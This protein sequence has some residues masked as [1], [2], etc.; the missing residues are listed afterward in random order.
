MRARATA[1]IALLL[2]L[3]ERLYQATMLRG[4]AGVVCPLLGVAVV[5]VVVYPQLGVAV[6]EGNPM[7]MGDA[8][9]GFKTGLTVQVMHL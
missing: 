1:V 4:F 5:A 2:F 8:V 6:G 3:S 9:R 7:A